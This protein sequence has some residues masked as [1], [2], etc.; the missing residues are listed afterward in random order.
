M[1]KKFLHTLVFSVYQVGGGD[2]EEERE[3]EEM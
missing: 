2:S 3:E 1:T